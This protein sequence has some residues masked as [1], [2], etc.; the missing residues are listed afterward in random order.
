MVEARAAS[1]A[2]VEALTSGD[3]TKP[4]HDY[5]AWCNRVQDVALDLIRYFWKYPIF[6]GYQTRSTMRKD[7]IRLLGSDCHDAHE[8]RAVQI[9]RQGLAKAA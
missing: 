3:Y 1:K 4:F 7:F 5:A 2:I 9:M 8:M 6:F